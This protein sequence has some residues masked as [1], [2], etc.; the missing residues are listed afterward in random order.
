MY[1]RDF[2]ESVVRRWV[3]A[4]ACLL[5]AIGLT[6][7][8]YTQVAPTYQTHA[9]VVLVPPKSVEEPTNNRYL[10]LG[11]LTEA[12]D[13]L[14]R[15]LGS[16]TT[17]KAVQRDAPRG[18]FETQADPT[19]SA[20]ILVVTAKGATPADAQ[21]V[22]DA[23]LV[24]IPINLRELQESVD[25][26]RSF[27]ITPE[28]VTGDDKPVAVHKKQIRA[29]GAAAAFFLLLSALV[30]AAVD[31]LLLGREGRRALAEQEA[32]LRKA[33]EHS[34]GPGPGPGAAKGTPKKP[35]EQKS[36]TKTK[37]WDVVP[38]KVPR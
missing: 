37:E 2:L 11:G 15:S 10:S 29:V 28:M 34:P 18:T 20:P 32:R 38:A 17:Q 8:V 26:G 27:Q 31:N 25:I 22:L 13:V 33:R 7:G 16:E 1:M 35:A 4:A 6:Y 19:T 21:K 36:K 5:A 9:D 30:V 12:V 14:T 23:V 24:Q 3:W